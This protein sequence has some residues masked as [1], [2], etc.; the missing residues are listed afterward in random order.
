[1]DLAR[2]KVLF[3]F[4][5]VWEL[6]VLR[7][8]HAFLSPL[9]FLMKVEPEADLLHLQKRQCDL[10]KKRFVIIMFVQIHVCEL[11]TPIFV[12]IGQKLHVSSGEQFAHAIWA[13]THDS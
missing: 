8:I 4:V 2:L 13:A 1:M 5:Q 7:K 11:D 6:C 3:F 10:D 12:P 9:T